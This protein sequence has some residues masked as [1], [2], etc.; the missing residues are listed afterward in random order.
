MI[1]Y[2]AIKRI[3]TKNDLKN[4]CNKI[5]RDGI[6]KKIVIK[7]SIKHRNRAMKSR[8]I[9]SDKKIK[10]NKMSINEIEKNPN[11]KKHQKPN[12]H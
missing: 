7:K 3:R 8:V 1:K 6:E 9:K 12:K 10:L 5:K 2:I 11:F 4:K